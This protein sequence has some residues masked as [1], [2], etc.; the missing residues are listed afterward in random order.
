M[1]AVSAL[2]PAPKVFSTPIEVPLTHNRPN[3]SRKMVT[4]FGTVTA[5][6]GQINP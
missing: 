1:S 5:V 2:T 3:E 4:L 6:S